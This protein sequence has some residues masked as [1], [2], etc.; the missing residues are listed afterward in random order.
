MGCRTAEIIPLEPDLD[1]ASVGK[2]NKGLPVIKKKAVPSQGD[3]PLCFMLHDLRLFGILRL[4][5]ILQRR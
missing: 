4:L 2:R 5:D 3:G 1:Y